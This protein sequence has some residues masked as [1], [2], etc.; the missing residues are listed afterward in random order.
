[1]QSKQ[2]SFGNLIFSDTHVI[3]EFNDGVDI[4]LEIAQELINTANKHFHGKTWGYISNRFHSYSVNPAIYI[5]LLKFKEIIVCY[6]IVAYR[7]E[8]ISIAKTEKSIIGSDYDCE[9]FND[10]NDAI[11]WTKEKVKKSR[12]ISN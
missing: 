1:M 2:F 10:L 11:H 5:D 3:A 8:T 7:N 12:E 6:A 4:N 9:V